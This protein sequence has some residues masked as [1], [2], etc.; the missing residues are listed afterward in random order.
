[1][2][3][4]TPQRNGYRWTQFATSA[5]ISRG[6]RRPFAET[7]SQLRHVSNEP[8]GHAKPHTCA[9][10]RYENCCKPRNS[11]KGFPWG[12]PLRASLLAEELQSGIATGVVEDVIIALAQLGHHEV[13]QISKRQNA[14]VMLCKPSGSRDS[15]GT[16]ASRR[17]KP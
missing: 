14:S 12:S 3:K 5:Y 17:R 2:T 8:L 13:P 4:P 9:H 6:L 11:L 15:S 10:G 1:M 7:S 16:H